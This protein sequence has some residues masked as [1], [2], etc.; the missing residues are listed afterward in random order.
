M[1]LKRQSGSKGL[2]KA[3]LILKNNLEVL[4]ISINQISIS[5]LVL[6]PYAKKKL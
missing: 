5:L 3:A 6:D 2:T 4:E 1:C